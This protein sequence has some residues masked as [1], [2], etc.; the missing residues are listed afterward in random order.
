MT[1]GVNFTVRGVL[2]SF[3]LFPLVFWWSVR[4]LFRPFRA[5]SFLS[6]SLNFSTFSITAKA[7]STLIY[8][9]AFKSISAIVQ[10]GFFTSETTDSL[11]FNPALK[12][13]NYTLLSTS[14]TSKVFRVK[15][16]TYDLRV[17]FSPC[18]M[19]N[20]WFA[21]LFERC[22][23]TMWHKKELLSCS[24]LS[25]DDVGNL[26]NHSLA[27]PLRVVGKEWHNISLGG[28]W[29]PKVVLKVLRWS[30][31]SFSPSNGLSYGKRNFKGIGHS[32]I[33]VVK[34]ESVLLTIQSRLRS[35]FSLI[36]F[37]NSSI[38]F[39]ISQKRF[40]LAPFGVT[41]RRRSSFLWLSPL[42]SR[43]VS[44]WLSSCCSHSLISWFYLVSSSMLAMSVWICRANAAG[45]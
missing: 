40:E 33:A 25:M 39:L 41:G 4:S 36:A 10:G 35:V 3:R 18:L 8:F 42:S 9:Y 23:L 13:V 31:G 11:D 17:S 1:K 14:S 2:S 44:K 19:V 24:K 5:S 45:S 15:R 26:V 16:F 20:R 29:R 28:Y 38:S 7:S 43:L 21:S 12:F 27:A 22:P 37:L 32:R 6:L 30:K 34:G